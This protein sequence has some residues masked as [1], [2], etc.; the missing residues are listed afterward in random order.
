M[1]AAPTLLAVLAVATGFAA[2]GEAGESTT[3][4]ACLE[5]PARYLDAL[6]RYP[7]KVE[8]RGGIPISDCLP[9]NQGA[10]DL[11]NAG[12]AMLKVA[13]RLNAEALAEPGGQAN[14]ELGYLL[15]AAQHGADRT[16]GIH[17]ELI[18]RLTA[19]ARY[20]PGGRP[21]PPRFTGTY[22]EGFDAGHAAG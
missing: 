19:A 21:L 12:A 6:E 5:G 8:L 3:P 4:V 14:L 9:E 15:G 17:V 1:R 18:R 11:A 2:C 22:R 13:T 20:S 16:E 10:G 7:G